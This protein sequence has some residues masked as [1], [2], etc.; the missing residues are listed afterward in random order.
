MCAIAGIMNLETNP[1][2]IDAF[3]C[4]M[5]RRGP[6]DFGVFTDREATLLHAR[7]AVMDPMGGRQPMHLHLGQNTYSLIYN[8]ELYNTGELR[9]ELEKLGH[10]F[11]SRCDTEVV[12]HAYA[13]WGRDCL[14]KFNGIFAF[15]V[16]ESR[17]RRL[18]LARDRIGVKPL[19]YSLYRGGLLFASEIKTILAYPGVPRVLDME[20]AAQILLLGPGR[21]PGSGVLSGIHELEPGCWAVWENG[22]LE[23]RRYWKLRDAPH[24]DSFAE[25]VERVRAL[26]EDAVVRQMEADV[27]VGTFLSGG[28]DSSLISAI[29]A[30]EM[31]KKGKD[32][33]TFSLDYENNDKFFVPGKF[34]PSADSDYI[35]IM[36][37]ALHCSAHHV[38]L[39]AEELADALEESTMARDLPGMA[40]VDFSLLLFCKQIRKHVTVALSG[41]CADEIFGGYPWYRDPQIREQAG[42]PW[43]QSTDQRGALMHH[44]LAQKIHAQEYVMSMYRKTL[45]ECDILPENSPLERRMKQMV[46]LNFRWFMQTLLDRKDRMSMYASLEVRVPFCDY[47][48]AEYLY[49][50]PWEMKDHGG[51]EKGL[52]RTAAQGLLPEQ[53]LWRK[54]SPYPKTYDPEYLRLMHQRLSVLMNDPAAPLWELM[55]KERVEALSKEEMPWPWYGQL[56]RTPQTIAYLLQI[57][58][59]IRHYGVDLRLS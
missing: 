7:L 5:Y 29:C 36:E 34:Q 54:K 9:Q 22:K 47:R 45:D 15:A 21:I 53:I 2:T 39:T 51:Y 44:G 33:D 6:D 19:F 13:Q 10:R 35:G 3:R 11:I 17:D 41:E 23:T 26:V 43:A 58:A 48:I 31:R 57:D 30:R 18:F 16:W 37:D 28:L 52:L 8:G 55:E 24:T 59:W 14:E 12:L 50:V 25:T 49:R 38:K 20:G 56:M 46:N 40:D 1:E 27:P 32:L 4:T 42:F